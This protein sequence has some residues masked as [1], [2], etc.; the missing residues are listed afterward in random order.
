MLRKKCLYGGFSPRARPCPLS[1]PEV[2]AAFE[3]EDIVGITTPVLV[4]MPELQEL[5]GES[6]PPA[7][8]GACEGEIAWFRDNGSHTTTIGAQTA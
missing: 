2:L 7:I 6:A 3:S 5:C 8:D 4:I 1:Q